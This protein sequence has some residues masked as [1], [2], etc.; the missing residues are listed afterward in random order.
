MTPSLFK[1]SLAGFIVFF[2]SVGCMLGQGNPACGRT[3][4]ADVCGEETF[5]ATEV[6]EVV[7]IDT[8]LNEPTAAHLVLL[9]PTEQSVD[10]AISARTYSGDMALFGILD[11]QSF[12][13]QNPGISLDP[14]VQACEFGTQSQCDA[15]IATLISSVSSDQ[16]KKASI[17]W[18]G[19]IKA[20]DSQTK[21]FTN[22]PAREGYVIA[23]SAQNNS[24]VAITATITHHANPP[25]S[26]TQQ[27]CGPL[28][29]GTMPADG[30]YHNEPV[31]TVSLSL[32]PQHGGM[33]SGVSASI[34]SPVAPGGVFSVGA[35]GTVTFSGTVQSRTCPPISSRPHPIPVRQNP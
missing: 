20:N 35:N 9:Q 28:Q 10:I 25:E 29:H 23:A 30:P 33:V 12:V 19:C 3:W 2:A 32:S 16:L 24:A 21:T 13:E 27:I 22:L 26:T 4:T 31:G 5:N 18:H 15:A 6:V 11:I 17:W 14:V 1:T 7:N 8:E 34:V